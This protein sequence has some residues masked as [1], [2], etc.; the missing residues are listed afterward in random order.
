[1]FERA[2]REPRQDEGLLGSDIIEH[3]EDF[4]LELV[5]AVP[6]KHRASHAPH[7][8]PDILQGKEGGLAG[9]NGGQR[10]SR[11]N[12]KAVHKT[13]VAGRRERFVTGY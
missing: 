13:I 8:G 2:A 12:Q 6:G 11:R 3:A 9:E 4:H 7:S 10:E 5:H 1:M